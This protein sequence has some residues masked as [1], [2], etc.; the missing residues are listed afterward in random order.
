MKNIKRFAPPVKS[1]FF[2]DF[3]P[4]TYR[5]LALISKTIFMVKGILVISLLL[6]GCNG[7][8]EPDQQKDVE[9]Q[10]KIAKLIVQLGDDEY[11]SREEASN[12]LEEIGAPAL[13]QLKDALENP[14][15]EIRDRAST[16]IE[17]IH[18]NNERLFKRIKALIDRGKVTGEDWKREIEI[19][20]KRFTEQ[21]ESVVGFLVEE[22]ET[23]LKYKNVHWIILKIVYEI[24]D[25]KAI[26][27]FS[28]YANNNENRDLQLNAI[29]LL[30]EVAND[31]DTEKVL[32]DIA[33][34]NFQDPRVKK[35]AELAADKIKN[36]ID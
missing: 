22:L 5:E 2:V 9:Q 23:N 1:I 15:M 19:V 35:E 34:D 36:R 32:R 8:G 24:E 20:K 25:E 4:Q 12:K 10:E 31:R 21:G 33:E 26:K 6:S 30:G 18:E 28:A 7:N 17:V 11:E 16:A 27:R 13:K 14:D 29:D 3:L